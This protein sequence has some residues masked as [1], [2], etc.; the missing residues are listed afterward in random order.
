MSRNRILFLI[1]SVIV[2]A[3]TVQGL[4][5]GFFERVFLVDQLGGTVKFAVSNTAKPEHFSKILVLYSDK[6]EGSRALHKN[7]YYTLNMSK[8]NSEFLSLGSD[9]L[10]EKLDNHIKG[11]LVIIA[12]EW[13]SDVLDYTLFISFVEKGG[14]LVVLT[15]SI[16]Q[17]LDELFGISTN[18]G[19]I[20]ESVY[21]FTFKE[22]IFPGLDSI[23]LDNMAGSMLDVALQEDVNILATASDLPVIWKKNFGDGEIM[24]VNSTI[25]SEKRNRGMLIQYISLMQDYFL[26]TIFN[27]KVVNIDDFPMPIPKGKHQKIYPRHFMST[28][29]FYRDIWWSDMYNL[30]KRFNLAYTGL[31]I[32]TYTDDTTYPLIPLHKFELNQIEFFGRQLAQTGGEI[33]IHGYN[34]QSLALENQMYH[35]D[36]GYNPWESQETMEKS[37]RILKNELT[38]LFGDIKFYTYV[39]PSNII[40]SEGISA[41]TNVFEDVVIFAGLYTGS[42]EKGVLYQE[43]G[44]NLDAPNILSFPRF[45]YGHLYDENMMW[46]IYSAIAHFGLVNHFIHPDDLLCE[47]RSGGLYWEE[48]LNEITKIFSGINSHFA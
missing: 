10:K 37:L 27:G 20:E 6:D 1:M 11:G 47:E 41:V 34:H 22:K 8:L 4:R 32:G 33:G 2:V 13:M 23:S 31:A 45:S 38:S 18:R 17:P 25:M 28:E 30:A 5:V 21:G 3:L 7:V 46:S 19:L 29:Q 42:P 36:Y 9:V 48:L 43:F 44:M 15:R 35:E 24:Y 26:M 14:K 16:F 39:P 12:T 40:S